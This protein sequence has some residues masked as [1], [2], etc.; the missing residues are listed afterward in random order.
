MKLEKKGLIILEESRIE[1]E[2]ELK[3]KEKYFGF[4]ERVKIL[5]ICCKLFT[6]DT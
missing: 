2:L 5:S 6:N 3:T 1:L 4:I